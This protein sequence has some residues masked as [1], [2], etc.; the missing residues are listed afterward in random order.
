MTSRYLAF[1]KEYPERTDF[2]HGA[3]IVEILED[4]NGEVVDWRFGTKAECNVFAESWL[5]EMQCVY[6]AP[7]EGHT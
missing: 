3:I 4:S 6:T 7:V 2:Q 1:F 5:G